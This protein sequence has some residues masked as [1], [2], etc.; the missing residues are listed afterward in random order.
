MAVVLL[1]PTRA[2]GPIPTLAIPAGADRVR[3]ELRLESNDFPSYRVGLK[4][5]ATDQ[6]LWR[7]DWIVPRPPADQASVSVVVP[8]NLLG[9]QHYVLDLTGRGAGG[10]AEVIGSYTVRIVQP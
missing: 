9:T 1:P 5:P 7:S 6:M 2:A 8:A 3:F 10:R 4:K